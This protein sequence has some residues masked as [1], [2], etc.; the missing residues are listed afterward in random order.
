M[1]SADM[2]YGSQNLISAKYQCTN[3]TTITQIELPL[4]KSLLGRDETEVTAPFVASVAKSHFTNME[5][6]SSHISVKQQEDAKV[7]WQK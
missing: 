1:Q 3:F 4:T 2:G 7:K 6:C 5:M